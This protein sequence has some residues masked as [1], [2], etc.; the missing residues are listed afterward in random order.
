MK[1]LERRE[2]RSLR[3]SAVAIMLSSIIG[4]ISFT[5]S[6]IAFLKLQEVMTGRPI[7]YP[8][9]QS[10]TRWCCW[11]SLVQRG[12]RD[13]ERPRYGSRYFVALGL[14]LVLGVLFVLPIGGA[15]MP[16]VISLLNSFTGLAAAMTG[17]VLNNNVL[18]ICGR[19]GRRLGHAADAVDGQSD[20]PLGDQR[21]VRCVRR[22]SHG[23]RARRA[24]AGR[25]RRAQR[26][27]PKTSPLMLAYAN[28]VIIVPGYG[29]AVAQAQ[30]IGQR[31]RPTSSRSAASR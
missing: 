25:R 2:R 8:G 28:Q 27:A 9:Q 3:R 23:R 4:A 12:H 17:F 1:P 26:H 21:A 20:E 31:A 7:T 11:R 22:R 13:R 15:D 19:A 16:V 6:I 18:I 30:H 29:M 14:A 10:S 5:G 24:R